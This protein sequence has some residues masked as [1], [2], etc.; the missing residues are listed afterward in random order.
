MFE[1]NWKTRRNEVHCVKKV[2]RSWDGEDID[3]QQVQ[4]NAKKR[5]VGSFKC[6]STSQERLEGGQFQWTVGKVWFW[7]SC[8]KN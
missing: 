1:K 2:D 6:Q 5:K 7:V 3:Q 4:K 8:V